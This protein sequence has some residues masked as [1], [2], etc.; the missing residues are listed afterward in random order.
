MAPRHRHALVAFPTN[1]AMATA[2]TEKACSSL[3]HQNHSKPKSYDE[4]R[5]EH[6]SVVNLS[7]ACWEEKDEGMKKPYYILTYETTLLV[8]HLNE[9]P[10]VCAG[11]F[12]GRVR[13]M[14]GKVDYNLQG[15]A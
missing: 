4:M 3:P 15:S 12:S 10:G 6:I 9:D 1:T 5:E 14:E 2:D 11:K 13:G 8:F 7:D